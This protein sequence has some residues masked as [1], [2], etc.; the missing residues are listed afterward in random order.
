MEVSTTSCCKNIQDATIGRQFDVWPS[1]GI[2]MGLFARPTWNME[3]PIVT[4]FKEGNLLY[5]KRETVSPY[6]TCWK[7]SGN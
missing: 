3:Q 4:L 7:P 1:S 2:L 5:K 6:C